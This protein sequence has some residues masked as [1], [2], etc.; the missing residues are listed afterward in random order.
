MMSIQPIPIPP[1]RN[2]THCT[3]ST[4]HTRYNTQGVKR[5]A[6]STHDALF[7]TLF[8]ILLARFASFLH[9]APTHARYT[10]TQPCPKGAYTLGTE[11]WQGLTFAPFYDRIPVR[12]VFLQV[13]R[14]PKSTQAQYGPFLCPFTACAPSKRGLSSYHHT[15][16]QIHC[17]G[18]PVFR[19]P[20]PHKHSVRGLQ[21]GVLLDPMAFPKALWLA[22]GGMHDTH[23]S[24]TAG[25]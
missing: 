12:Q 23:T 5:G 13:R 7:L 20:V 4:V 3:Q 8:G 11:R 2:T 21:H 6:F 1:Q 14:N 9:I 16:F 19:Q 24:A 10:A 15:V 25:F 18:F 22:G 17:A